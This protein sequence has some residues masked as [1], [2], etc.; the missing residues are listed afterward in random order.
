MIRRRSG[1]GPRGRRLV[2]ALVL[3]ATALVAACATP[4]P[5]APV[6]GA[7]PHDRGPVHDH[8]RPPD[9][10]P[11]H[12]HA[13]PPAGAPVGKPYRING[14][15]YVPRYDPAYDV[16]GTASWYGRRFHGRRTASGRVFDMYAL[17]AAHPTLPFDT[18]VT[19]TNLRNGRSV[20]L[21]VLDRGPFARGRIIDVS[22]RAAELLGFVRQGTARVRVRIA[23]VRH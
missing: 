21:A 23:P 10:G 15:F 19:V 20:V 1:H 3:L 9:R 14:R 7:R 11:G 4:R 2:A 16:V 22:R 12:H 13:R 17:T 5:A 8:A 18:R 6:Q